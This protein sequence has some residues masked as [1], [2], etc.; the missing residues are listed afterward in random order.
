MERTATSPLKNH[1]FRSSRRDSAQFCLQILLRLEPT[2][3]G[4]YFFNGLLTG[5]SWQ[6]GGGICVVE[7]FLFRLGKWIFHGA[8]LADQNS[9]EP[10]QR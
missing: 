4:Y 7:K 5:D 1:L 6:I 8:I 3:V 9:R 10:L 2:H